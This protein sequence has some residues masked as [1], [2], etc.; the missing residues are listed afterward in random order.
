[1]TQLGKERTV[2]KMTTYA[3]EAMEYADHRR[4]MET[5]ERGNA[6]SQLALDAAYYAER[7][8][9]F[10]VPVRELGEHYARDGF[11]V[12]GDHLRRHVE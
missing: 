2:V 8:A 3:G 4:Y 6:P 10:P 12:S 11:P 5:R 1:M 9:Q 7:F